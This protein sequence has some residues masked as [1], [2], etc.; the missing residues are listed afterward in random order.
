MKR[1]RRIP[2]HLAPEQGQG[3]E[4]ARSVSQPERRRISGPASSTAVDSLKPAPQ[5]KGSSSHPAFFRAVRLAVDGLGTPL[6]VQAQQALHQL[7]DLGFQRDFLLFPLT[8][9]RRQLFFQ[10]LAFLLGLFHLSA[11]LAHF[12]IRKID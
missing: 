12:L 6:A 4:R 3:R 11:Q 1:R 5:G 7:F 9:A 2:W 8:I 10:L